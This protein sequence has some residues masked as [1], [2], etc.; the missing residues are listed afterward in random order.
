[1]IASDRFIRRFEEYQGAP[2]TDGE[3]AELQRLN[4]VFD[5]KDDD[6]AWSAVAALM[7]SS[8]MLTRAG[9]SAR[10]NLEALTSLLEKSRAENEKALLEA[11]RKIA[12]I[13]AATLAR[14]GESVARLMQPIEDRS[15]V[16]DGLYAER[17]TAFATRIDDAM[18]HVYRAGDMV[19]KASTLGA[20]MIEERSTAS[21]ADLQRVV[22]G[23]AD[24]V[25]RANLTIERA[26]GAIDTT[27]R[28]A[29]FFLA[30]AALGG[31]VLLALGIVIGSMFVT[32][33]VTL[34]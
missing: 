25:D 33:S 17:L 1:M 29:R 9:Q 20:R 34:R 2:L 28:R 3:K 13:E 26:N 27:T 8:S 21:I 23:F 15:E 5:I 32:V 18:E 12:E 7:V 4:A 6:I 11:K 30:G 22:D 14:M 16:V 24:V 31:L 19:A 10:R